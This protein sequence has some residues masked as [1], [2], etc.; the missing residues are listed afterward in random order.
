[1]TRRSTTIRMFAALAAF[2]LA[3]AAFAGAPASAP[4]P[5]AQ[6]APAA[7]AAPKPEDLVDIN[8]ATKEQ[9]MKL[10]GIGD[11]YADKIIKNRPYRMKT[12]LLLK[13]VMPEATYQKIL[14]LIIAKQ[15]PKTAT[16]VK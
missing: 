1:M 12:E 2:A 6:A 4:T 3:G 14:M 9:L 5:A 7:A 15:P 11:A 16:S 13:K 8:S 10:P